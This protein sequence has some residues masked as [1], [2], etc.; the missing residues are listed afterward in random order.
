MC[1]H[2]QQTVTVSTVRATTADDVITVRIRG[3]RTFTQFQRPER[4]AD[5]CIVRLPGAVLLEGALDSSVTS[6]N[7]S[8]KSEQIRD[9]LVLRIKAG[10]ID[11]VT[12]T[13]DGQRD[14]LVTIR[15]S[16]SKKVE[17]PLKMSGKWSLDVIVIDA[18]H[19]GQD[20]GAQGVNGAFEKDVTLA[21]ARQLRDLLR[22]LMPDTKVVMTRD[23]DIFIELY[24]RTQIANE[25]NGK[26]FVSIHC[27][28]M[29][30]KPHPAH[31]CET[32]ILRPGRNDD[33]TRVASR[34]NASIQFERSTDRYNG[35]TED[36]I[37]I[38]TMAQRS[39]VRMSENLAASIQKQTSANTPLSNRGVSQAGFFVLV[40]A[41]MPNVLVETGFLS[42]TT[43]AQYLVSSKGQQALARAISDAIQLY[44][45]AY[46]KSISH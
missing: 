8:C 16:T 37:I 42:N 29:P 28:S 33:A 36:Q 35:M 46:S 13:R 26:L 4:T 22:E 7:L 15:R 38:A 6:A 18:G 32:Y 23:S 11:S 17:P 20:A 10:K 21:I 5:G 45:E 41:S 19:G 12:I 3:S 44:A 2:A 43:D 1:V 31:G 25:S 30:T 24:R 14:L 39:F 40:G 27:N 9:I 34:E